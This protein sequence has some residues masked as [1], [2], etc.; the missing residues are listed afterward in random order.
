[1]AKRIVTILALMCLFMLPLSAY[2]DVVMGND[3]FYKNVNKTV[4]VDQTFTVNSPSG[5]ISAKEKPGSASEVYSLD[6]GTVVRIKAAYRHK[7]AYWGIPP[8]SHSNQA[9]G[10]LPMDE[11]LTWYSLND[12]LD[13]HLDEFYDY[14]GGFDGLCAAGDYYIWQW[15]GSDR[16]K[17]HYFV[18]DYEGLDDPGAYRARYAWLDGEGREWLYTIIFDGGGGGL[19]RFGSIDGWICIDDPQNDQIPAFNPAP[20]PALWSPPDGSGSA[21]QG[22]SGSGF[23][24]PLLIVIIAAVAAA[25]LILIL[26][27]REKA[28]P[29]P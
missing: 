12:F 1:M 18:D 5:Q 8:E 21:G 16:E 22:G 9:W 4:P 17:V 11:L 13:V 20:E 14:A 26:R 29:Q 2:A 15:P 23:P 7:G 24:L 3:F 28:K 6:N 19:S 27:R 25:V 10:W